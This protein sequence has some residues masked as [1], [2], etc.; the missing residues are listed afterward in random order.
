M[1]RPSPRPEP[2]PLPEVR[3][4]APGRVRLCVPQ[5]RGRPERADVLAA[6]LSGHSRIRRADARSFTGSVILHADPAVAIDKLRALVAEA[7][8]AGLSIPPVQSPSPPQPPSATQATGQAQGHSSTPWHALEREEVL[9]RIGTSQTGGLTPDAAARRLLEHGPNMTHREAGPSR[10]VIMAKQF[11]GLPVMMLAGSAIISIA[12]GGVADAVATLTVVAVNGILGYVTE[13]QAE[14]TIHA[15]TDQTDH[16]VQIVRGGIETEVA[17]SGLV[18]GDILKLRAGALVPAD[19]RLLL[20]DGLKVDESALTGESLPVRKSAVDVAPE[21]T[22]IGSRKGMLYSGTIVAEGTG[23]AAIVATGGRT[24]AAALQYLSDAANRPKAPV[25][26]E[27]DRLGSQ[28]AFASLAACTLFAGI[29]LLRGYPVAVILKDALALAVAAVPEG[30]PMV[31]TSTLSMGLRRMERRGILVR[32]LSAVESMG[33]L[34]VLCLDK[35]GTL[36][37]NRMQVTEAVAGLQRVATNDHERLAPICEVAVLNNDAELMN[38]APGGSSQ[39]EQSILDCALA[40]G[41]DAPGLRLAR[42]RVRTLR[43]KPSRPWMG[44]YHRT[45]TGL[46]LTL[47]GAP[48]AILSRCTHVLQ[49]SETLPLTET[50]KQHLLALND[51]LASQPARVLAFA[52]NRVDTLDAAPED[53]VFLGFLAMVDPVRP[54]AKELITRIRKAGIQPVLI[55]GDQAATAAAVARE[56]GLNGDGPLRVIDSTEFASL[57]P[58]LLA[59]LARQTHV[60]ARVASHQKLAIVQSLQASGRIVAMTGDGI[61]D[62]PALAAAD[63][64]IAM[65]ESGTE[66]ARDVANVVIRDDNLATLVEAIAEGRSIYRNIRRSLEYLVTTNMSEIAVS[67]LEAL[68]GPGE[69]ETP[70]ELLWVNMVTDVLPGL[71]LALADPDPDIMHRPPRDAGENIVPQSDFRRMAVDSGV[72]AISALLSHAVGLAR[73]GPGPHTRGMTFL[74]LSQAQ[75]LYTLVCQRSDPRKLKPGALLE[76]RTLDLTLLVSAALGALPFFIPFLR[77][78]LGIAPLAK[79][80]MAVALAAAALPLASVLARRNLDITLFPKTITKEPED[81]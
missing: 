30:L 41:V 4:A 28:L 37:Q 60:F 7:L 64:G 56:V 76:N 40:N 66:L 43:R 68:H 51:S 50:G 33:A 22:P 15:L 48:E 53:M 49:E 69:L 58:E 29:G 14:R 38:G 77:R 46:E 74:T 81:A 13:G 44:T 2:P 10:F 47:K 3:H 39:T 63:I 23:L 27:L 67:I 6:A 1:S 18:P 45:G 61:N 79:A 8:G 35:T 57:P 36:T 24:E 19:A 16:P 65:G 5:I 62:A 75:L 72:I 42:P 32:Q 17:A 12:S 21:N 78:L 73:Y 80:D 20:D 34:Q 71:G 59:A 52:R 55:T 70:M 11:E 31:A 26:A 9:A 54:G 25:E